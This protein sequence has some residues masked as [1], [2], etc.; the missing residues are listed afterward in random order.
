MNFVSKSLLNI[1]ACA[2]ILLA[3]QAAAQTPPAIAGREGTVITTFHAEGAQVYECKPDPGKT[4]SEGRPLTWQFREPIA[5]LIVDGK[6]IGQHY[7]APNWQHIDGSVVKGKIIASAP[8][9]TSR[10]IPWLELELAEHGSEGIFSAATTV[11]RINT[12]G[13]VAQG[14]CERAGDYLSVPYSADYVFLRVGL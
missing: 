1:S 8:G 7:A 3:T 9:A 10:D 11:R 13:G 4:Q 6:S 2:T 14:P 5:T 12:K